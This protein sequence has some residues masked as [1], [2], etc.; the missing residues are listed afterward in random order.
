MAGAFLASWPCAATA[1]AAA[2]TRSQRATRARVIADAPPPPA[3]GSLGLETGGLDERPPLLDLGFLVGVEGFR[4][5][6]LALRNL[7]PQVREA[8]ARRLVGQGLDDGRVQLHDDIPGGGFRRPDAV[9][10]RRV[11][12]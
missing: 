5:L 4:C 3:A 9:P 2:T 12:S 11:Q 6:L 10:D 8:G 7:L 1:T